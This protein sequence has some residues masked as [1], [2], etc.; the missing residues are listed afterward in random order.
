MQRSA[1]QDIRMNSL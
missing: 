1:Q